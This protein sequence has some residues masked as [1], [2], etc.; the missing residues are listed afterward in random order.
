MS[1]RLCKIFFCDFF[2]YMICFE[3]CICRFVIIFC[4]LFF[5]VLMS[6]FWPQGMGKWRTSDLYFKKHG[7]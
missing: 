3:E 6:E 2:L 7:P 5:F 1:K 4:P